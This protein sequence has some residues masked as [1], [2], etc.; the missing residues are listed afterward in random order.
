MERG[1]RSG[2]QV[3]WEG[4]EERKKERRENR[5]RGEAEL[6]VRNGNRRPEEIPPTEHRERRS[7]RSGAGRSGRAWRGPGRGG[8]EIRGIR[9]W[10]TRAER[11]GGG[12][13]PVTFNLIVSVFGQ[14]SSKSH[15]SGHASGLELIYCIHLEENFTFISFPSCYIPSDAS[16]NTYRQRDR[17][18]SFPQRPGRQSDSPPRSS[19][20]RA[21]I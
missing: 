3:G 15:I 9:S 13:N 4:E 1:G 18:G 6:V 20:L 2:Q 11:V 19:R 21:P 16:V 17:S 8:V 12:G 10:Q 5:N 7:G 14:T